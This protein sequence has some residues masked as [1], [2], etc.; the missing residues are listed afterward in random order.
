MKTPILL[1]LFLAI[2]SFT[3]A[4]SS[5]FKKYENAKE[6][7]T[8]TVTKA[9]L[10]MMPDMTVGKR[11]IR[12]IASKI[13]HL[14][15]LSSER[16]AMNSRIAKDALAIYAKR[17]WEEVMSYNEGGSKTIIYMQNMGKGKYE[18]ALMTTD[19]GQ[20]QIISI[21]GNITLQDIKSITR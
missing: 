2:S 14:Q 16:Q 12:K 11:N 20:L 21:T 10:R 7:T 15:V 5:L 4:Q 17:P 3:K 9:M 1:L 6:V 19:K 8:V 18:Y 13:D